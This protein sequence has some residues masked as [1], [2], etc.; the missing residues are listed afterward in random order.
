MIIIIIVVVFIILFVL[1]AISYKNKFVILFNRVKN[2]WSQIDVHLQRRLDLIPNLVETVKGY[3]S[4][5][6]GTLE[7][8]IAA[9]N[10]YVSANSVKEKMEVSNQ[11]SGMLRQLFALSEAYPDLKANTNFLELQDQLKEVED[12]IAFARQFYNDTVTKY[13]QSIQVFPASLFAGFFHYIEEPL[14]QA[15][16]NAQAAPKVQF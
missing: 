11:L 7:S 8:V 9:R 1:L 4:H 6:K 10:Q 14:F 16:A 15:A 13:N 5:E 3:A 12:K 2:A